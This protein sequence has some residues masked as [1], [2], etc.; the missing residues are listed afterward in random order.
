MENKNGQS[1]A[2]SSV[3]QNSLSNT[4]VPLFWAEPFS[5]RKQKEERSPALS[6]LKTRGHFKDIVTGEMVR[7]IKLS[8]KCTPIRAFCGMHGRKK[9]KASAEQGQGPGPAAL[10]SGAHGPGE[11]PAASVKPLCLSG[12]C[13]HAGVEGWV[14]WGF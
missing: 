10:T 8:M 5:S 13:C 3:T 12:S 11:L 9:R 7:V 6:H 2:C 1:Y 14:S 4:L